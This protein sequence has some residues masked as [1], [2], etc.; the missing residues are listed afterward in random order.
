MQRDEAAQRLKSLLDNMP[1]IESDRQ[2]I[3][4]AL[5]TLYDN[6]AATSKEALDDA[7]MV[8][9]HVIDAAYRA[10]ELAE[11]REAVDVL[12]EKPVPAIVEGRVPGSPRQNRKK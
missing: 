11:V 3:Y 1:L 10:K 4:G 7:V 2:R 5:Q 8:L 6:D 9:N 12:S